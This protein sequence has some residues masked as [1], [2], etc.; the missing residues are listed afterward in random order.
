M[1]LVRRKGRVKEDK[2]EEEGNVYVCMCVGAQ[3]V[4]FTKIR[5]NNGKQT[6]REGH[7]QACRNV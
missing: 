7:R 6:E 5:E 2:K 3:G 1:D 4:L